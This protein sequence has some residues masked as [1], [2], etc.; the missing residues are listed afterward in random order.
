MHLDALD[1]VEAVTLK[2]SEISCNVC[3]VR[4]VTHGVQ[5]QPLARQPHTDSLTLVAKSL[6]E[7]VDGVIK[8]TPLDRRDQTDAIYEWML[9]KAEAQGVL[10]RR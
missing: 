10:R 5:G 8:G 4:L 7:E 9:A 1:E 2:P 6:L 3:S